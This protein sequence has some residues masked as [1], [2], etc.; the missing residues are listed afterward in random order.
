MTPPPRESYHSS[1]SDDLSFWY[2]SGYATTPYAKLT[3]KF[4]SVAIFRR[5]IV[6]SVDA[7]ELSSSVVLRRG[8]LPWANQVRDAGEGQSQLRNNRSLSRCSANASSSSRAASSP[9]I[10]SHA[11]SAAPSGTPIFS[12][13]ASESLMLVRSSHSMPRC[14]TAH[15]NFSSQFSVC[16]GPPSS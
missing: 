13:Q 2:W 1:H 11:R 3:G 12:S 7:P 8:V 9:E 5:C 16:R 14:S 10:G 4:Q 6:A 15:S